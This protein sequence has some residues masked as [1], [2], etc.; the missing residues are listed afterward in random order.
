MLGLQIILGVFAVISGIFF[1]VCTFL[2]MFIVLYNATS[3]RNRITREDIVFLVMCLAGAV[4]SGAALCGTTDA[5][6]S[7]SAAKTTQATPETTN[8]GE[9][10]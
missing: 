7:I 1:V 5:I 6:S 9:N 10:Q 8:S 3:S 4:L 2:A